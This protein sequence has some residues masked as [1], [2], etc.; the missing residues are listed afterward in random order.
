M[1]VTLPDN[2]IAKV[3]VPKSGTAGAIVKVDGV[4]VTGTEQGDYVY[5]ENIGSGVHTFERTAAEE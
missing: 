4:D 2:M 5:V 1:T 3:Y